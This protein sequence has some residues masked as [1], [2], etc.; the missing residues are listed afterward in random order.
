[1]KQ[2]PKLGWVAA[3]LVVWIVVGYYGAI[4]LVTFA[5]ITDARLAQVIGLLTAVQ[6]AFIFIVGYFFGSSTGST[7]K[8]ETIS[9]L[10]GTGGGDGGGEVKKTLELKQ[11]T[12]VKTPASLAAGDKVHS[13]AEPA[14]SMT[15]TKIDGEFAECSWMD[16]VEPKSGRFALVTL[17]KET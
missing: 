14:V 8:S 6:N 7:S 12:T 15:I 2:P 11:T 1:M 10:T 16:G 17:Q 3:F 9:E 5:N 4:V 13:T